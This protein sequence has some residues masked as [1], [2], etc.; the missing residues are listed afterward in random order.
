MQGE[1]V[2]ELEQQVERPEG[3]ERG[4]PFSHLQHGRGRGSRHQSGDVE[5]SPP[6][7]LPLAPVRHARD[8]H[9]SEIEVLE[10]MPAR[11]RTPPWSGSAVADRPDAQARGASC[12]LSAQHG[13]SARQLLLG[14]ELGA[15]HRSQIRDGGRPEQSAISNLAAGW[16]I[17]EK[18]QSTAVS[19][20][21][22]RDGVGG[23]EGRLFPPWF[24]KK[25]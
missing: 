1:D 20:S 11:L 5:L 3:R 25:I 16:S 15:E 23:Q 4:Q 21:S 9:G 6:P 17:A 12:L 19:S 14:M 8:L 24:V 7:P 2:L 10:A 18:Q 13:S 22:K